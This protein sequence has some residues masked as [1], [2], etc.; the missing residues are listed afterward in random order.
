M[1]CFNEFAFTIQVKHKINSRPKQILGFILICLYFCD[2]PF[3]H[4]CNLQRMWP[5]FFL[6]FASVFSDCVVFCG[7]YYEYSTT[8]SF[9]HSRLK[10]SFSANHSHR[11]F[12]F[13]FSGLTTLISQT[14]YCYSTYEHIRFYFL[15]FLFYTFLLVPCG[16]LSWLMSAFERTLK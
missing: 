14:F 7:D 16:R 3:P 12:S 4:M 15:V 5:L 6:I 2:W 10:T 9:F 1:S 8:H 13:S 11:S